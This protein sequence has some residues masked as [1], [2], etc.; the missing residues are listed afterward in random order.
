MNTLTQ[1]R[2][3]WKPIVFVACLIPFGIVAGKAIGITGSLG[4]NPIEEVMDWLG[5]WGIRFVMIALA[6]TP[7][8]K[9]TGWNWLL[10]FRRMLGLFAFFYV[11]MHFLTWFY[12]DQGMLWSAIVE[13]IAEQVEMCDRRTIAQVLQ[14][15]PDQARPRAIRCLDVNVRDE[16]CVRH[17][18][19]LALPRSQNRRQR[20]ESGR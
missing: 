16:N 20:Q 10:R 9:I 8:R 17:T 7:L 6:V 18:I 3:V 11:L 19:N 12:L 15:T 2:F 4:A 1:I 14:D 13:D 5:N